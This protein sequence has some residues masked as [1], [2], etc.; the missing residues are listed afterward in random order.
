MF[1]RLNRNYQSLTAN[2][3][4]IW[5]DYVSGK[6]YLSTKW[7]HRSIQEM[8]FNIEMFIFYDTHSTHSTHVSMKPPTYSSSTQN[9][10]YILYVFINHPHGNH[11]PTH[12][13]YHFYLHTTYSF[14][15]TLT[16]ITTRH[17]PMFYTPI[18]S[19]HTFITIAY[20]AEPSIDNSG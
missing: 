6:P 12:K 19:S 11:P 8:N 18:T 15:N 13:P 14:K 7:P 1:Q 5:N 9:L 20:F 2:M 10:F 4:K 17:W 3:R 16:L